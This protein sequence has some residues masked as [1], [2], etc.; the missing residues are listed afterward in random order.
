L[1]DGKFILRYKIYWK[2]SPAKRKKKLYLLK[3]ETKLYVDNTKD[4]RSM[5]VFLLYWQTSQGQLAKWPTFLL[6]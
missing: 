6:S 3:I 5:S 4:G 1:I 2:T